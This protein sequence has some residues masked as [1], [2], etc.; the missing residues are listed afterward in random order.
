MRGSPHSSC[1]CGVGGARRPFSCLRRGGRLWRPPIVKVESRSRVVIP[2]EGSFAS[3]Y[4][5]GGDEGGTYLCPAWA[6]KHPIPHLIYTSAYEGDGCTGA[7]WADADPGV[8]VAMRIV[9]RPA[10]TA[11]DPVSDEDGDSSLPLAAVYGDGRTGDPQGTD[12]VGLCPHRFHEELGCPVVPPF[13]PDR[14]RRS[15]PRTPVGLR[16]TAMYMA[17]GICVSGRLP[18]PGPLTRALGIG[19]TSCRVLWLLREWPASTVL[20]LLC[21]Q[22]IRVS[23][24]RGLVS[25]GRTPLVTRR[26]LSRRTRCSRSLGPGLLPQLTPARRTFP[27]LPM[28]AGRATG[29][30]TRP[31]PASTLGSR[32]RW[33]LALGTDM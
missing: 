15:P 17:F 26:G 18:T 7:Y 19:T 13:P 3:D 10:E 8:G 5:G 14:Q 25:L 11:V 28:G 30:V 32:V 20:W 6:I 16:E 27:L 1:S 9:K 4:S 22:S 2:G 31:P 21:V 24:L 12:D 23:R 33:G 29:P